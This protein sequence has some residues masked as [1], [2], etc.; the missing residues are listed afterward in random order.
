MIPFNE[1]ST[2]RPTAA[3]R[4]SWAPRSWKEIRYRPPET[5][6]APRYQC[7]EVEFPEETGLETRGQAVEIEWIDANEADEVVSWVTE[8]GATTEV[9]FA[10][11][12]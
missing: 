8:A 5:T 11:T 10:Q 12:N 6:P 4:L 9:E 7:I 1:A 3:D 2:G